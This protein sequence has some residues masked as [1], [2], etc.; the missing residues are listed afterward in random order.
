MTGGSKGAEMIIRE[1]SRIECEAILKLLE[2]SHL[3]WQV[4]TLTWLR[5]KNSTTTALTV[6]TTEGQKY[7]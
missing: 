3:F 7:L 5:G 4:I 6:V 2:R 1:K